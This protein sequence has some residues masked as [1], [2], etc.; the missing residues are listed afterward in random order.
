V[1]VRYMY[2]KRRKASVMVA[3]VA[4]HE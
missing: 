2:V 4:L 3:L 1:K